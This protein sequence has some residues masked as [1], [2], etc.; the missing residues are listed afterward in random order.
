MCKIR[1]FKNNYDIFVFYS[2]VSLLHDFEMN[3]N[4]Q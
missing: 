4:G 1:T 3:I 2:F